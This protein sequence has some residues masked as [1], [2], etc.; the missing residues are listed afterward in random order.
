MGQ[1]LHES[2]C[3]TRMLKGIRMVEN[4]AEWE[5]KTGMTDPTQNDSG[6]RECQTFPLHACVPRYNFEV[7]VTLHL[8]ST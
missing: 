2:L 6:F 4:T 8:G 1:G 3:W 7:S 5:M